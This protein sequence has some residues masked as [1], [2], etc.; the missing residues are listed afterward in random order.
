MSFDKLNSPIAYIRRENP[1]SVI[2]NHV[3]GAPHSNIYQIDIAGAAANA[4]QPNITYSGNQP[5]PE[6][7]DH[8]PTAAAVQLTHFESS[9]VYDIA[10]SPDG[11]QL[12]FTADDAIWVME[13]GQVPVQASP[14]GIA[15]H[16][17]WLVAP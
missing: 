7:M 8:L 17:V 1:G 5:T 16:P 3:P 10:W 12:A 11:R 15:R 2:A 13:P 14:P 6:P 4:D 9:L